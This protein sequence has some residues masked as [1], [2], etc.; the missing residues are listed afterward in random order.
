VTLAGSRSGDTVRAAAAE[1]GIAQI[2]LHADASTAGVFTLSLHGDAAVVPRVEKDRRDL[3]AR[4]SQG[5]ENTGSEGSHGDSGGVL[6][7]SSNG[8]NGGDGGENATIEGGG[9]EF[10]RKRV[11]AWLGRDDTCLLL[12]TSGTTLKPKLVPI[13]H[14]NLGTAALCIRSTLGLKPDDVG[15]NIMPLHHLHGIMVNMLVSAVS[16]ASVVCTEGWHDGAAFFHHCQTHKATWYVVP[17][18]L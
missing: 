5:C 18:P 13:T 4:T 17:P 3:P 6:V 10:H 2:L 11:G 9:G 15:V 8:I 16:G 14:R 12:H 7:A 1:M